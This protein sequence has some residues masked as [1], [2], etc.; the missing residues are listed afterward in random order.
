MEGRHNLKFENENTNSSTCGNLIS[1]IGEQFTSELMRIIYIN[2]YKALWDGRKIFKNACCFFQQKKNSIKNW[3]N[4]HKKKE[5]AKL[6]TS[7]TDKAS[8]G[9]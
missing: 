2:F 7:E 5:A 4:P 8:L 9:S 6:K 3:N 1:S